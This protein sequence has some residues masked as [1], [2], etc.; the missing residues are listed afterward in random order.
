MQ[1]RAPMSEN[2]QEG[3][4]PREPTEAEQDTRADTIAAFA[5]ILIVLTTISFYGS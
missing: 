3:E 5:L 2:E 1:K 4:E